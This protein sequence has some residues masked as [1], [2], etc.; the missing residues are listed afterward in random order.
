MPKV[1]GGQLLPKHALVLGI[2]AVQRD[3]VLWQEV[4][5]AFNPPLAVLTW[6]V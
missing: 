1:G 4:E 3:L 6:V 5:E 2:E